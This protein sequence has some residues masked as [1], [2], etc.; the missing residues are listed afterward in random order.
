MFLGSYLLVSIYYI[1]LLLQAS[2]CIQCVASQYLHCFPMMDCLAHQ[3]DFIK[4]LT[5]VL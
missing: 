5:V 1:N 2:G 4:V 3:K